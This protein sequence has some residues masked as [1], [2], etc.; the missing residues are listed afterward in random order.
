MTCPGSDMST[1]KNPNRDS[2][3][4]RTADDSASFTAAGCFLLRV[5]ATQR[6][7]HISKLQNNL[8]LLFVFTDV[9]GHKHHVYTYLYP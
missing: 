9:T 5:T 2:G 1:K 8:Q 3:R 7:L 6:R 4:K